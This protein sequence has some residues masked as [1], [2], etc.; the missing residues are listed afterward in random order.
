MKTVADGASSLLDDETLVKRESD[1][2]MVTP[3]RDGERH[4]RG[5]LPYQDKG[6]YPHSKGPARVA[7]AGHGE[8]TTSTEDDNARSTSMIATAMD[9][10]QADSRLLST[11]EA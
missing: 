6:T 1:C 11:W 9:K 5:L 10:D 7:S 4:Q 8:M 3:D 2:F